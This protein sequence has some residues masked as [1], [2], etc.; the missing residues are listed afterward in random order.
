MSVTVGLP[1]SGPSFAARDTTVDK[2]VGAAKDFESLLIAQMLKSVRG[3]GSWLGSGDDSGE[4]AAANDAALSIGEQQVAKALT[5]GGGFG[6]SR[7]IAAGL[8]SA[9]AHAAQIPAEKAVLPA[10]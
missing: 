8:R 6:I 9:D 1:S 2:T 5:A 4:S 7:M 3:D 10:R